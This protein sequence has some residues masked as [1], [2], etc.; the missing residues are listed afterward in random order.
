MKLLINKRK[1]R[2]KCLAF[3][4]FESLTRA[5][6]SI[7]AQTELREHTGMR[8]YET[9]TGTGFSEQNFWSY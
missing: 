7:K 5:S 3:K 2:R 1:K 9:G 6:G 8:F 4:D